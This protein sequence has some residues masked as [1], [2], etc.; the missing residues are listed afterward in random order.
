M[1]VVEV[2]KRKKKKAD[3][4]EFV[5]TVGVVVEDAGVV[6]TYTLHRSK[7]RSLMFLKLK[8]SF[9]ISNDNF[10][11]EEFKNHRIEA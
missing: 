2:K 11:T 3:S 4:I 8:S 7:Y 10:F 9:S 5:Q 6:A 1:F